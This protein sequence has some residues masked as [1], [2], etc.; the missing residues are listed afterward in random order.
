MILHGTA[1]RSMRAT[2]FARSVA[3]L[4]IFTL[5]SAGCVT[6]GYRAAPKN[7]PSPQ[8][9]NVGF[10]PGRFDAQLVGVIT[11]N[12]PG[13]WKR[14]AFWDEYV[15]RVRNAGSEPVTITAPGLTDS[16][17]T[18]QAA[19]DAPWALE[20]KSRTLE[21]QYRSQGIAFVRYTAPGLL[22]VGTG[23]AAIASAGVF[24]AAAATAAAATVVALPLYYIAVLTINHSNKGAMEREF[25]KRRLVMPLT[26]APGEARTG[27][28][29]F[30]MVPG[31]RSLSLHW[32]DSA[33]QGDAALELDFL[34]DLHLKQPAP[35]PTAGPE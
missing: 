25:T 13:S 29:F 34:R 17:G 16:A 19:G 22:I 28:L 7:T 3:V 9:L 20:K 1:Q 33:S 27:S 35:S 14:N 12:G 32:S 26:L 2:S 18:A 4:L 31:P 23:A 10:T 15:V 5:V 11:Y 21:R 30:P 24:S 8:L 6:S